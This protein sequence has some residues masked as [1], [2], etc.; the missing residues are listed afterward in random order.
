[1]NEHVDFERIVAHGIA[2]EGVSPPSDAFYEELFSRAARTGPRP[3]WLALIK[4]APMRTNNHLAVGSPTLRLAATMAAVL[5]LAVALAAAGIAGSRLMAA[6]DAII[7]AADGSGDFSTIV[8]AVAAAKDGDT[9]LIRPGG[10]TEP[11]VID[12]DITLRGDGPRE[13]IVLGGPAAPA[14]QEGCDSDIEHGCAFILRET[15]GTLADVTLRG[16]LAGL[17]IIGGAPTIEGLLFDRD[18]GRPAD[19]SPDFGVQ[20]NIGGASRAR[21]LDNEFAGEAPLWIDEGSNPLV[22][23]NTLRRGSSIGAGDAGSDTIIRAN[24]ISDSAGTAISVTGPS[25]MLIEDNVL[26]GA[27]VDGIAVGFMTGEGFD[28]IIRGNTITAAVGN[29][30]SLGPRAAPTI[31]GNTLADNGFGIF[32]QSGDALVRHNDIRGDGIGIAVAGAGAPA[33]TGNSIDVTGRG[34][35][36]TRGSGAILSDN[37]VCGGDEDIFVDAES[38]PVID[39]SNQ[40]CGNASTE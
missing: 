39:S 18:G 19:G 31:E 27:G 24:E 30:I 11:F 15:M 37:T 25:A 3:E 28:P 32:L 7:V 10:Y 34:I 22:E 12:K 38:E 29:A 33:I 40:L 21:V 6:D 9:L 23:G 17:G 5:L 14:N 4:E 36:L 20:L 13:Q 35:S 26:S 1:M 16:D 8:E 2:G